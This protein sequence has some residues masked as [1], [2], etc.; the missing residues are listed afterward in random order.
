[1]KIVKQCCLNSLSNGLKASLILRVSKVFFISNKDWSYHFLH[2]LLRFFLLW[3]VLAF[4]EVFIGEAILGK[5]LFMKVHNFMKSLS[6]H[7]LISCVLSVNFTETSC[8]ENNI[9]IPKPL[10]Y[11]W[12][13]KS[14]QSFQDA[15][16]L[17]SS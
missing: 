8:R 11:I 3:W 7:C 1:M 13:D 5:L 6:D 16:S 4:R 12:N 14:I 2:L 10:K 17:P 15:L 9:Y